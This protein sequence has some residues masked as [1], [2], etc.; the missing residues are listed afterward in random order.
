MVLSDLVHLRLVSS[1]EIVLS[2]KVVG[3]PEVLSH[4]ASDLVEWHYGEEMLRCD[5]AHIA[6][7][8]FRIMHSNVIPEGSLQAIQVLLHTRSDLMVLQE[9]IIST[10]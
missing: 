2:H 9:E 5:E 6:Q 7:C 1:E 4:S 3:H 8:H 10:K